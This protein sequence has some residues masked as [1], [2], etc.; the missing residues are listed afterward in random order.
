MLKSE[1]V[2]SGESS[3]DREIWYHGEQGFYSIYHVDREQQ[4]VHGLLIYRMADVDDGFHLRSVVDIPSAEWRTDHWVLAPSSME[5]ILDEDEPISR[6]VASD[7]LLPLSETIDDFL[8]VQREPE[9]LSYGQLSDRIEALTKKGIDASH[10]LV[11]L[12]LK[13]A[14]PFANAVLAFVAI[15]IAGRLRRHPSIAAIIGAGA[16][17]GFL[18]WVILGLATSLGQTGTLPPLFAAWV[19]NGLYALL[20]VA[21]FLYSE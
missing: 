8:E 19:A 4:K 11:D 7:T 21:L 20:G 1:A 17:V 2:E 18:Y 14:L 9:E 5:H 6:P 12:Y 16:G 15:P 3:G 10:Y 13:I